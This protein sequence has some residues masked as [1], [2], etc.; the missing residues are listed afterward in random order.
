MLRT[1][2]FAQRESHVL[3]IA[4]LLLVLTCLQPL[5]AAQSAD[6]EFELL[7]A[8][9]IA[10][11]TAFSPVAATLVGDHSADHEL[12]HVDAAARARSLARYHD[13]RQAL[14]GIDRDQLSRANQVDAAVLRNRIDSAIWEYETLQQW[15]WNPLVYVETSGNAIYG[16]VARD[17]APLEDRLA[18]VAARLAQLPRY[19]AQVRASIQ[20]QRVPKIHAETAVQQNPG[21]VSIIDTMVVPELS[22]LTPAMREN[23]EAAI[24]TA[25]DAIAA[26]Q[27]WLE[28]EL[29][30]KAAGEFRIGAELY[31]RKLAFALNSPLSRRDIR[32][33]AEREYES[34]RNQMYEVARQVY[35]Q[36]HP[37][38]TFPDAPDE[39]YKQVII[40]T[41]LEQAYQY[42]PPRDGIVEVAREQLKQAT[43]F[44]IQNNIV[45]VPADPVEIIIMPE[46]ERGVSLA[47]LDAP[48]PL[49]EGQAAFYAV[50][51]LPEE[52][53]DAQVNSFLR[54][55]NLYSMQ[56]LTI[57]EGVPGHFLQLALSNR[58][59]SVLRGVLNSGSFV[60]GWAVY[61]ERVMIDA[62]Y[63]DHDPL[64]RLINLKW[65]LRTIT[66]AIIDSAIHVDGMT[67]D[68]AIKLMIEGSFQEEREAAG[69]WVRAQLTS[70]Q[71]STYFV[72]Y[73]EHIE[74]RRAVEAAWGEEFTLR[75]YHDQALS[76]G[77][78]PV[79]YVRALILGEPIPRH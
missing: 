70:A 4:S 36:T 69:K 56:D 15:A 34:V 32:I 48:G 59:P 50:A 23:L 64:M 13:Y 72:G 68:Q 67:R 5:S 76:Y 41:A 71:L 46:F 77:S 26:H 52:W 39:A 2:C 61:A 62:G 14:A 54:E 1:V 21:L 74:M 78:P 31:D 38:T 53:T 51:P 66:N 19:F 12:D 65:Y 33:R 79:R 49:D 30:P 9:Y 57:H 44:V 18:A 47:Y 42:L 45:T 27:S 60:E 40:R 25:K 22:K 37:Y 7:A 55:Y 43:E 11:L 16:L 3:R 73:Q 63:L 17:F 75:R 6:A 58:Y 28:V 35:L 20:A 29:L 24:A 10:D 8:R